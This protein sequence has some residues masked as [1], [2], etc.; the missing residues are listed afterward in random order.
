MVKVGVVVAKQWQNSLQ[1]VGQFALENSANMRILK[2]FKG[3][4]ICLNLLMT[5]VVPNICVIL[6]KIR[7]H[8]KVVEQIWLHFQKIS[9]NKNI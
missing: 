4:R 1:I 5:I 6:R 9:V 7:V 3:L 8:V 2:R